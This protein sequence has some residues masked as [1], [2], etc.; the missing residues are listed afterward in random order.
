MKRRNFIN[1]ILATSTLLIGGCSQFSNTTSVDVLVVN[2]T[3]EKRRV[4]VQAETETGE[5]VFDQAFELKPDENYEETNA[6]E[7]GTY[8]IKIIPDN[9]AS[10]SKSFSM[11]GCEQQEIA[12]T[13]SATD[14][15]VG[16]KTC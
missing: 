15:T 4:T 11:S 2:G 1:G 8:Q 10:V 16:T 7:G 9:T 5:L 6:F 13:V 12:I 3:A 14:V